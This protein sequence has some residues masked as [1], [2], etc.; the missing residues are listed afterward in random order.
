MI[1][2]SNYQKRLDYNIWY[3]K[4]GNKIASSIFPEKEDIPAYYGDEADRF[5]TW[6]RIVRFEDALRDIM[7]RC[8]VALSGQELRI[9]SRHSMSP[10]FKILA[11][12]AQKQI[13]TGL[14]VRF[15]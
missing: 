11:P 6:F 5:K 4:P 13:K 2:L 1:A 12:D 14:E 15:T 7:S 9:A 10:Y 3:G 8:T